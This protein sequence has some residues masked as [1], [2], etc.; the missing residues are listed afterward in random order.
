MSDTRP[1][2]G[3]DRRRLRTALRRSQK[4]SNAACEA[5]NALAEVFTDIYG[6]EPGMV[7]AD[8]IIDAYMGGCGMS[9]TVVD[10]D[11]VHREMVDRTS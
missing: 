7:D 3:A 9:E 11:E 2:T 5:H 4:A 10:V 1:L 8:S 6:A